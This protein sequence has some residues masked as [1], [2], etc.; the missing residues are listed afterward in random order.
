MN[1]KKL[2]KYPYLLS[3]FHYRN[4]SWISVSRSD[5]CDHFETQINREGGGPRCKNNT[6]SPPLRINES[7]II[8][9]LPLR[10]KRKTFRDK[11]ASPRRNQRSAATRVRGGWGKH[12]PRTERVKCFWTSSSPSRNYRSFH[13]CLFGREMVFWL[14]KKKHFSCNPPRCVE[15]QSSSLMKTSQWGGK[16]SCLL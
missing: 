11:A 4:R 1:S 9:S 2:Q 13:C 14:F 15:S 7:R 10:I 8:W 3:S 12:R 5:E 6:Y 16:R